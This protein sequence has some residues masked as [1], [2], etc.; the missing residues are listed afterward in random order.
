MP[1]LGVTVSRKFFAM[2]R[3]DGTRAN[4]ARATGRG[5][6]GGGRMDESKPGS[7]LGLSIVADLA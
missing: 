2:T 3:A 4:R 1:A 7:G 5:Q 6:R